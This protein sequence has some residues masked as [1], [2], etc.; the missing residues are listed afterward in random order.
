MI[1]SMDECLVKLKAINK[2]A[3]QGVVNAK[4]GD[5]KIQFEQIAFEINYL[6]NEVMIDEVKGESNESK[7]P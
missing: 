4:D 2:L 7:H 6:I 3:I 1:H 5:Q